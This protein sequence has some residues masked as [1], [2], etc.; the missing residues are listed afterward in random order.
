MSCGVG[1]RHSSDPEVL[2]LWCRPVA[3][4]PIRPLAWEPPY[5]QGVAQETA[6]T[7]T[8]TPHLP[9]TAQEMLSSTFP[10]LSAR[11]QLPR[12]HQHLPALC[13]C[14][15]SELTALCEQRQPGG[16]VALSRRHT[17]ARLANKAGAAPRSS[18][19]SHKPCRCRAEGASP[20]WCHGGASSAHGGGR[21]PSQSRS[22]TSSQ[23]SRSGQREGGRRGRLQA[24]P[25]G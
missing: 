4:T 9:D 11:R 16:Q 12:P 5:A 7:H 3:M 1:C 6:K 14:P 21:G 23:L 10:A 15:C 22:P 24:R 8:H 18:G 2:W 25:Y 19:C 20:V 17:K 13:S